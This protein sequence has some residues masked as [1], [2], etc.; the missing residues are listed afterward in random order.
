MRNVPSGLAQNVE[1]CIRIAHHQ[2]LTTHRGVNQSVCCALHAY[3]LYSLIHDE[4]LDENG[5]PDLQKFKEIY[6]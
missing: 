3:L 1:D 2:S 5:F 4:Y 6:Q